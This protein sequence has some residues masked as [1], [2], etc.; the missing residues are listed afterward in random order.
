VSQPNNY[1]SDAASFLAVFRDELVSEDFGG[2]P[3]DVANRI[4][5][6]ATPVVM[7]Y[8]MKGILSE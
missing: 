5:V 1:A 3:D 6:A 2:Y 4:V 8:A 7:E